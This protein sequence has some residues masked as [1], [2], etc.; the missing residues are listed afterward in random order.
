MPCHVPVNG[1]RIVVDNN[2]IILFIKKNEKNIWASVQIISKEIN[3]SP[4]ARYQELDPKT[5]IIYTVFFWELLDCLSRIQTLNQK[6]TL[7]KIFNL[8]IFPKIPDTEKR[9]TLLTN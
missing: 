2:S 7:S 8:E 5:R 6:G 9:S 1:H 4:L 3:Q